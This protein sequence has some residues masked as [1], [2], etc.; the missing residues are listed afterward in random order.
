MKLIIIFAVLSLPVFADLPK[1]SSPTDK[2]SNQIDNKKEFRFEGTMGHAREGF[3]PAVFKKAVLTDVLLENLIKKHQLLDRWRMKK[4]TEAKTRIRKKFMVKVDGGSVKV[5][6]QD[7]DKELAKVM[8]K[9][10]VSAY[11]KA[12]SEKAKEAKPE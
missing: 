10:I 12:V 2:P 5:S 6:Y 11:F 4:P 3:D 7:P 8:L 1:K 9:S